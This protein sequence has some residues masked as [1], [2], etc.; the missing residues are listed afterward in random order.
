[1]LRRFG[2]FEL[3]RPLGRGAM[4]DVYLARDSAIGRDVAVKTIRRELLLTETARERFAREARA[5]GTLNHPSVVTVHEFGEADGV[6]FLAME[7]VE[8]EDL[9]ALLRDR[10]LAPAEILEVMAQ[11]CDGL[12]Y[13]HER[14]ILHRDIKPS[15]IRVS[16]SRGRLLAKI[17]DFGIARMGGSDLTGSGTLLGT[18]SYM[19]PEYVQR[20]VLSPAADLFAVGVVLHEALSGA[21]LFDGDSTANILFRI[22]N[23]TPR[24]LDPGCFR[25]ISPRTQAVIRKA[26]AKDPAQRFTSAAD[27]AA[28][29]REAKDP[30]WT[31]ADAGPRGAPTVT[32]AGT[33][34]FHA[35]AGLPP[36]VIQASPME[37]SPAAPRSLSWG[38]LVAAG[39]ALL[40]LGLWLGGRRPP[41]RVQE[42]PA[43]LATPAAAPGPAATSGV[44][45][46]S[47]AEPGPARPSPEPP[48]DSRTSATAPAPAGPLPEA[49]SPEAAPPPEPEPA[50]DPEGAGEAPGAPGGRDPERMLARADRLLARWPSLARGHALKVAALY[51][52]GRFREMADA[53]REA[54]RQGVYG[55][56]MMRD[57]AF[58]AAAQEERDTPRIPE[59]D[60]DLLPPP[61]GL[62]RRSPGPEGAGR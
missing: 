27:L 53:F 39:M 32:S 22:V 45:A 26:L 34:R 8:G 29:L 42:P 50:G 14:G 52:L 44:P 56:R 3:I 61:F 59:A 37:P 49:G 13:A 36:T 6:M 21:R 58:A 55:D 23:E 15:N 35:P 18:F 1:M 20:G 28:A 48:K 30:A 62:L 4:G 17:M 25:G 5:A 43:A 19:A 9:S 24:L 47:A 2:K 16:R 31:G 57:P 7:W 40:S 38:W 12:A 54:A 10:A 46:V 51:R 60:R 41:L 11:V 33:E